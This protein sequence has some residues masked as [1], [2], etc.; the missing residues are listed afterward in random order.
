MNIRRIECTIA[1]AA[2][3]LTL[4]VSTSARQAEPA[5]AYPAGYRTW[6]HVRT[7]IVGPDNPSFARRG[8]IHHYYA[9]AQAVDGYRTGTFP[10]GSVIVDEGVLTKDGDGRAKGVVFEAERRSLDVMVKDDRRFAA[11]GGWG[12]EHYDGP[13]ST[14]TLSD[15]QRKKCAECH[16]A[17]GDHDSVFAGIRP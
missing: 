17:L 12:Y 6:Q 1:L 5:V 2:T 7:I 3:T 15:E 14:P 10:N 4:A 13:A 8:G 9:N 11:T 16:S